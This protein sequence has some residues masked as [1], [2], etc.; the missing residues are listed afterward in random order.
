MIAQELNEACMAAC[1]ECPQHTGFGDDQLEL[2]GGK[3][4]NV[5][6]LHNKGITAV[7]KYWRDPTT[8]GGSLLWEHGY[9]KALDTE[10]QELFDNIDNIVDAAITKAL[11]R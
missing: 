10:Y 4:V 11:S 8:C 5:A 6:N 7:V 1:D 9:Y 2:G 3:Y